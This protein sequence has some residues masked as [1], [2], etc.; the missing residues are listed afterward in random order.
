VKK[1]VIKSSDPRKSIELLGKTN[2]AR[3]LSVL[4]NEIEIEYRGRE[5]GDFPEEIKG[6][7]FTAEYSIKPFS[8]DEII[9]L[10]Y[11]GLHI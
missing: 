4:E 2:G 9:S 1:I 5:E 3:I 8:I 7:E 10:F 6:S 11:S